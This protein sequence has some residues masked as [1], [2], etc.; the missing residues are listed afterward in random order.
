MLVE[1]IEGLTRGVEEVV[2][3]F[4]APGIW[5]IALLENLFPP[6]PSE[7]LYPLAGKLAFDGQITLPEILVAGVLGSLTGAL[8]YYSLGYWL[9]D[10][11]VRRFI[12]R[13]GRLNLGLFHLT[14]IGLEDYERG[15]ALFAKRGGPIVFVARIMP[16]VHGVVSIPAG[17]VRMPLP[18]F[19]F[20]TVIGSAAWIGPLTLLGYWLGDNWEQVMY[21]LEVYEYAWYALIAL[22]LL[23]YIGYRLRRQHKVSTG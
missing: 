12:E 10:V 13:Y 9:G 2:K 20:Y 22:A 18:Q 6:T 5:L 16:L 17:V 15:L 3:S 11:R 4:G 7:A 23:L 21:W 14:I 8:L 1:L 19:I